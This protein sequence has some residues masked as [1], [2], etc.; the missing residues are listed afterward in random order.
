MGAHLVEVNNESVGGI[1]VGQGVEQPHERKAELDTTLAPS[2]EQSHK[3]DMECQP[4]NGHEVPKDIRDEER[5]EPT[6]Q[7]GY[8][9]MT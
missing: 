1:A 8:V 9:F 2:I 7:F 4:G 6:T 5:A 3:E